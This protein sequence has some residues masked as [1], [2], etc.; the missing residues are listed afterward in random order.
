MPPMKLYSA[1]HPSPN[2]RR[3]RICAAMKRI[4]LPEIMLDLRARDHR[5]DDHLARNALGQVP[6]LELEDGTMLSETVAI[7][8]YLDS[9][10]PEPPLF[11]RDA[12]EGARVEMWTRRIETQL[13][14]PVRMFWRHAHPATAA[15]LTQHREFGE[16]NRTHVARAMT[17]LE[18]E[19]ATG[20][21]YLAADI[22]TMADIAALTIVDFATLIGLDP[23]AG[24][25]TI[26]AWHA[27]MT[28][29]AAGA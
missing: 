11:G 22:P 10:H 28:A 29:D 23:L 14:E 15:L 24:V 19:M 7:C 4:D 17:W 12:L 27:R 6:V 2:P 20:P 16:S 3:V 18:G 13:G 25:P 8:R 1:P 9:L 26:G 5:R 21:D